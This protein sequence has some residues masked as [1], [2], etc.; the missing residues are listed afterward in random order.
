[1]TSEQFILPL[2]DNMNGEM[3]VKEEDRDTNNNQVCICFAR[4]KWRLMGCST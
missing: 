3:P 1:M 4:F 2:V